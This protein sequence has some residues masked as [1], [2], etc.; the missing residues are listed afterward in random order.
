MKIYIDADACPNGVKDII[1]RAA[2]K[3]KIETILVANCYI[4]PPYCSYI[5]TIQVPA[6]PDVADDKIV[7]M[8][9]P[10]DL[11]VTADIPLADHV[12]TKKAFAVNPRGELYTESNIRERLSVRDFMTELRDT[13]V[14]TGGP[15]PFSQKDCHNFANALNRFI[16][17]YHKKPSDK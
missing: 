6:G 2:E 17:K 13:G 3:Q 10:G 11:V 16:C 1:F 9:E 14:Q 5:T 4:K 12:V 15:P 8:C 7:E